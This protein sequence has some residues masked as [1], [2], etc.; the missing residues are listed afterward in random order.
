M[1]SN[2]NTVFNNY[3]RITG[4]LATGKN[5]L[6]EKEHRLQR[7]TLLGANAV[8]ATIDYV[9]GLYEGITALIGISALQAFGNISNA[10]DFILSSIAAGFSAGAFTGLEQY[11][12]G[13]LMEKTVKYFHKSFKFWDIHRKHDL[14]LKNKKADETGVG[15]VFGTAA[16]IGV[17]HAKDSDRKPNEDRALNKRL[18]AKIFALNAAGLSVAAM[19]VQGL[20]AN[21]MADTAHTFE[22]VAKNP[23]LYIGIFGLYKFIKYTHNKKQFK[24]YNQTLPTA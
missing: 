2:N 13:I 22:S 23:A 1:P 8:V 21:G 19:A 3:Q 20:E 9:P 17:H 7:I 12:S 6:T 5:E 16:A 11:V 10:K 14:S 24:L 15:L 18:S 4:T